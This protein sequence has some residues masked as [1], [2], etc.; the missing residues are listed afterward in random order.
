MIDEEKCD[1]PD[2]KWAK[3]LSYFIPFDDEK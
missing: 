1:K 2:C 3:I